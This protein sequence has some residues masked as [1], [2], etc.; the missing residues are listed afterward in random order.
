MFKFEGKRTKSLLLVKFHIS[1][2]SK[3]VTKKALLESAFQ[4]GEFWQLRL[5]VMVCTES[6]SKKELLEKRWRHD[7]HVIASFP[8]NANPKLPMFRRVV[9]T[10]SIWCLFSVKMSFSNFSGI[11]WTGLSGLWPITKDTDN[12]VNVGIYC[13][14][15]TTIAHGTIFSLIN[16]RLTLRRG[17]VR[18]F[19]YKKWQKRLAHILLAQISFAS[20]YLP[21]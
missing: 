15:I 17:T 6:I 10:E 2:P 9:W 12:P 21:W 20:S 8:Q 13:F 4:I 11:M 14:D 3:Y 1:T 18:D 19:V 16:R 7:S 5:G